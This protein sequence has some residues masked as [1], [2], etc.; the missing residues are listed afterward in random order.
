MPAP[1]KNAWRSSVV[2]SL[3]SR[4][5]KQVRGLGTALT[6]LDTGPLPQISYAVKSATVET[7]LGSKLYAPCDQ[8]MTVVTGQ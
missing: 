3:S 2:V 5:A 8:L 1:T 6:E 4:P 7:A